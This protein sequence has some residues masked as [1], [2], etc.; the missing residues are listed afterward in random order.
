MKISGL[1]R[2][3]GIREHFENIPENVTQLGNQRHTWE[4]SRAQSNEPGG[5]ELHKELL[6]D[7]EV[8]S[9]GAEW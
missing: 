1:Q 2:F 3:S 7:I 4:H 6:L 8:G 9:D 5:A